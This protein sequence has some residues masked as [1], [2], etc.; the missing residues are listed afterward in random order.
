M[1]TQIP[2]FFGLFKMLGQ[3]VE[4]AKRA[5]LLGARFI[6][7]GH[8]RIFAGA[9]LADQYHPALHGRD[10]DL[11]HAMTPKTGGRHPATSDDVHPAD[12]FGYLYNLAAGFGIVCT[13]RKTFQYRA[14]YY[15][16]R[17]PICRRWKSARRRKRK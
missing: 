12:L 2:I 14:I 13:L 9:G 15:N 17:Q 1:M 4:C 3:A 5:V 10:P 6:P 11:A 7:A 16:K 8:R